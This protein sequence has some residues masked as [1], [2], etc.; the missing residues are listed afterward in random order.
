MNRI[1]TSATKL[2]FIIIA[3][4]VCAAYLMGKMQTN[5]FM[6]IATGVFSYYF[7]KSKPGDETTPT[8]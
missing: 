2:V 3:I 4:T 6:I 5:E 1:Y 7:T 8:V